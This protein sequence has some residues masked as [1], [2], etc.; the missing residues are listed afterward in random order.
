MQVYMVGLKYIIKQF[1]Y[2]HNIVPGYQQAL[3]FLSPSLPPGASSSPW[4]RMGDAGEGRLGVL[5]SPCVTAAQ[6]SSVSLPGGVYPSPWTSLMIVR[7]DVLPAASH[8]HVSL[9]K[10]NEKY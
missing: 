10:W 9:G 3:E 6:K 5:P 7:L 8:C 1:N 2:E 4:E